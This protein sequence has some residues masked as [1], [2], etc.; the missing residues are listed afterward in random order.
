MFRKSLLCAASL[1]FV[2]CGQVEENEFR[3]GLPSKQMV[4]VKAPG[5][6]GQSLEDGTVSALAR[7]DTSDFYKLTRG[8]TVVVN[9]GTVA[10]LNLI[11]E[12]TKNP[13][14]TLAG[15]TA[16]WG[17]HTNALSPNTWKLTVTQDAEHKYSYKL[18]GK[19]KTAEDTAF[20]VILSGTH[21][22]AT[23]A[24][25]NRQ[26]NFGSGSFKL[27]WDAAQTLPER[28]SEVGTAEIRYTRPSATVE[29]SV[30]ADFRNVNDNDRPGTRINADYRYKEMPNAGGEFD[31]R[32]DKN[33][34]TDPARPAIERLTIKSRWS[35]SGAGRADA[36]VTQGDVGATP[37][38]VNECWDANFASQY[39]AISFAPASGYGD[40]SACGTYASAVYSAL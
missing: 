2:G 27:D 39:L 5:T 13:P 16:V 22:I 11:E 3:D 9:G 34:D 10:V 25:G 20:K 31:F 32:L 8:A 33:L 1:L 15:D 4:E 19:A 24:Q 29:A 28:G 6:S 23:D 40:V 7:G 18:E 12:I 14:T 30:E 36:R 26:R 37:A 38:T 17:P 35:Q 21:T